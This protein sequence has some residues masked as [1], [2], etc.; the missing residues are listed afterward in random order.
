MNIHSGLYVVAATQGNV[1]RVDVLEHLS[2]ALQI[3]IGKKASQ[4]MNCYSD[5]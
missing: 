1:A 5:S 3:C 2:V 4:V